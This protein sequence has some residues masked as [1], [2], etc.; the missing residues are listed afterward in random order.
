MLY[1]TGDLAKW[2]P[3]GNIEFLGRIDHQVKIRGFRIELGEIENCLAKI[4]YIKEAV[5][6]AREDNTGEMN[7]YAYVVSKTGEDIDG[8]DLKNRLSGVLPSYMVPG[9]IVPLEKIPLTPSGKVDRKALPE[10]AVGRRGE[11]YAAPGSSVEMKLVELWSGVLGMEKE[12][13]SID[14]NFFQLGGNSLRGATVSSKLHKA[15]NVKISLAEIFKT[16]TI[17]GLSR[18]INNA[19]EERYASIEPAEKKEYHALSPAQKRLYLLHQVELNNV[20][21]NMPQ[22]IR[23]P[24]EISKERLDWAFKKLVRRHESLRTSFEM[25]EEPVQRIHEAVDFA[26]QYYE[27][28]EAEAR[29]IINGFMCPFDLSQAPLLRASLIKLKSSPPPDCA[30]IPRCILLLDMHHI[31]TDGASQVVL[32]NEFNSL[33]AGKME[34]L[35]PLRLQYKDYARWQTGEKQQA[36]LKEQEAYWLKEFGVQSEI[37]VLDLPTDYPRPAVQSFEGNRMAFELNREK[38]VMLNQIARSE[39]ATLFMVLAAVYN[40]CLSKL[41]GQEDIVIGTPV[42]GRRHA[43]LEAIIGMFVNTLALRNYPRGNKTF[44]RFLNDLKENALN[45]FENQDYQ[46]EDLVENVSLNLKRDPS[47]NPLFD[48][49]FALQNM[50][51][52]EMEIPGSKS[53][54]YE[55]ENRIAK[56]DL[57][58]MAMETGEHLLFEIEYCTKLFKKETIERLIGFFK[59]VIFSIIEN[60][61][62]K[63]KE[64]EII[65][66]GEKG[67]ILNIFNNTAA[68]YPADRTIHQLFEEQ[69]TIT[70]G[71]TAVVFEDQSLTYNELNERADRLASELHFK[72]V[73]RDTAVGIMAKH[74]LE[75]IIGVL[76]ILKAGGA[77]LP[78]NPEYPGSRKKYLLTDSSAKILLTKVSET[79]VVGE[80]IEVVDL[81]K[82]NVNKYEDRRTGTSKQDFPT[83]LGYIIYTSGSTGRPKG[84]MVNHQNVVR[85][86][87]N[88]NYIE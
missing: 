73:T 81:T 36:L 59:R 72:G 37:P 22:V 42:A 70:P 67:R 55:I 77:Y 44:T 43:D 4:D 86:V 20:S 21:Y 82:I 17:R 79:G 10:P 47:R 52:R 83:Q 23:F 84:V 38:T 46:F 19:K 54:P 3:D 29:G 30:G 28:D 8:M 18:Y 6:A 11:D 1:Q 5:A 61:L 64:I 56:F 27:A 32:K 63:I 66:P 45:A 53:K 88:T 85:L 12:N 71:R 48:V 41:T 51:S 14:A 16:P 76:A 35:P 25:R 74:S 31:I 26:V 57:S 2:L 75:M 80:D 78:I 40:I 13:I 15:F 9:Y 65:D 69:V 33:Y 24:G 68:P 49:L 62:A 58:V 7:L 39:G 50:D 87:K 60:P 34:D